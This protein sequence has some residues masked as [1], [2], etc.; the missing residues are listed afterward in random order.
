MENMKKL[1]LKKE[2]SL[3]FFVLLVFFMPNSLKI[4]L[5]YIL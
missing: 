3:D 5:A 4:I 2:I 1:Y